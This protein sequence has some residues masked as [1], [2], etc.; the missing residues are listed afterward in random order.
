MILLINTFL[1]WSMN[2][3]GRGHMHRDDNFDIFKYMVS[4]LAAV[5]RWSHCVFNIR[6]D[7]H[8]QEHWEHLKAYIEEEFTGRC[9]SL[10]INNY[11]CEYQSQ[12]RE[13]VLR[14]EQH[15]DPYIWY[16][17]NH[18]HVV[19][20]PNNKAL[21]AAL[22]A[23]EADPEPRKSIYYSHWPEF[24]RTIHNGFPE[25]F[26]VLPCG[27]IAGRW[28]VMDSIQIVSK[29]LL[30]SWWVT[31]DYGNK[32]VPRSDWED[33]YATEP[34]RALVPCREIVR[35]YDGYSHL[36]DERVVPPL[37]IPAGFFERDIKLLFGSSENREGW[38]NINPQRPY[39]TEHPEGVDYRWVLEDVPLFWSDRISRVETHVDWNH[40]VML[41]ARNQAV[42]DY[43]TCYSNHPVLGGKIPPEDY[44]Q[45]SLLP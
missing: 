7:H 6:L 21:D 28:R 17:C 3:Y 38:V 24:N 39:K 9:E 34:Y 36:F 22:A 10:E 26:R 14:L 43:M 1:T 27:T 37:T 20:A 8:Y 45:R 18:D 13:L 32:Y 44:I 41:N 16:C 33:T 30:H 15:P 42:R 29:P 5:D 31:P 25:D 23:L 12:W 19:Y 35:H 2:P 40:E 11:R 4:S